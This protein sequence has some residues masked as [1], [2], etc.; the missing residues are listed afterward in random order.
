MLYGHVIM[1]DNSQSIVNSKL[2]QNNDNQ[3]RI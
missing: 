2:F 3:A 1:I